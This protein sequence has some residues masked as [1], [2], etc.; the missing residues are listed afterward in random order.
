MNTNL[1]RATLSDVP[2]LQAIFRAA[3][4]HG[5]GSDYDAAQRTAWAAAADDASVF[6]HRI[7]TQV[8]LVATETDGT[9][10]AFGSL[11]SAQVA[12]CARCVVGDPTAHIDLLYVHPDQHRRGLGRRLLTALVDTARSHGATRLTAHVSLTAR[13]LFETLGFVVRAQRWPEVRGVAMPNLQMER[14]FDASISR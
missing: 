10:L 3:V 2:A 6:A 14:R 9:P 5:T 1:R 12:G 8:F 7:A 13:P 11:E 4:L